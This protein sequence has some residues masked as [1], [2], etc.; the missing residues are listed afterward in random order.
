M[1]SSR[2]EEIVLEA[3]HYRQ[4]H[5]ETEEAK[6]ER[7]IAAELKLRNWTSWNFESAIKAPRRLRGVGFNNRDRAAHD[8]GEDRGPIQ[9]VRGC[10]KVMGRPGNQID[11]RAIRAAFDRRPILVLH[12]DDKYRLH[13]EQAGRN[14][15]RVPTH[16]NRRGN[17]KWTPFP[18]ASD[19]ESPSN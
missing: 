7:I 18:A 9:E 8:I 16:P 17:G 2:R 12:D 5:A 15:A 1:H 3:E 11:I 13:V 4:E 14:S 6:A 19:R 10:L